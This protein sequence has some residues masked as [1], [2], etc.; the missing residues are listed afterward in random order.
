MHLFQLNDR[1]ILIHCTEYKSSRNFT[2]LLSKVG[3]YGRV[4]DYLIFQIRWLSSKFLLLSELLEN[5]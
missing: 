5:H 2:Q 3:T 4:G 1:K